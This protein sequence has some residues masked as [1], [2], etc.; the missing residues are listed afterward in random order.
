[1]PDELP[2]SLW[3]ASAGSESVVSAEATW[4]GKIS[5]RGDLRIEGI[6]HGE[7]ET[8]G[9][10]IVTPRAHVDGT[11]LANASVLAGEIDGQVLCNDR[12]EMLSGCRLEGDIETGTL[13]VQEGA[14]LE[15]R[16]FSM[17]KGKQPRSRQAS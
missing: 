5:S 2:R 7:L 17:L 3:Q 6:V 9:S 4:E 8:N 13:V 10:L 15:A 12:L 14:H 1:M 16:R 11:V